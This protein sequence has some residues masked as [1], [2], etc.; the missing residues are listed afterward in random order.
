MKS[1]RLTE[2]IEVQRSTTSLDEYG[3]PTEAWEALA[4][5]RGE[6]IDSTTEEFLT[7]FGASEVDSVIFKIRYFEGILAS[8]R[9]MWRDEPFNIRQV[10]PIGRRKGFELR[11]TRLT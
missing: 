6:R 4:T 5:L 11:C 7:G 8:D 1:G 2:V 9:V 10:T 3:T